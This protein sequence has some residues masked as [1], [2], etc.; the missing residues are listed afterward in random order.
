MIALLLC[1]Q[2]TS[3]NADKIQQTPCAKEAKSAIL[4]LAFS[5]DG[6]L[7]AS[8]EVDK[9]VRLWDTATGKQV[10][11]LEGH[12]KQVTAVA[13]TPDGKTLCSASYDHTVRLWDVASGKVREVQAGD[14]K[15]GEVPAV[16][17]MTA[18]FN[19]DA[20]L[21]AYGA[22]LEVWDLKAKKSTRTNT[23]Y[24]RGWYQFDAEGKTLFAVCASPKKVSEVRNFEHWDFRAGKATATWEGATSGSYQRI[25][26]TDDG[27]RAAALLASDDD[28]KW[29]IEIWSIADKKRLLTAGPLTDFVNGMSFTKDSSALATA[30]LDKTL[31][32]WDAKSGK[33]LASY[34]HGRG[35]MGL[36]FSADGTRVATAD[37]TGAVQL[38]ALK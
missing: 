31:K 6:K 9:K 4:G 28:N 20:S 18:T 17:D 2:I 29:T 12:T 15:K 10:A 8:G 24:A 23:L 27:S 37:D 19:R 14:P 34:A 33:E 36:A 7:L 5:P 35:F 3:A 25:A 26:V 30:C 22:Y 1:L 13:F 32:F 11:L 16:E 21:L 38:W